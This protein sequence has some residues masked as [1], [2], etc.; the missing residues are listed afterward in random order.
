MCNGWEK[1]WQFAA[2]T[3]LSTVFF[4]ADDTTPSSLDVVAWVR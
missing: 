1:D 4:C 3:L 2:H